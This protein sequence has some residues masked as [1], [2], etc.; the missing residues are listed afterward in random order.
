[1]AR[2]LLAAVVG[3]ALG[4]SPEAAQ[5]E[6]SATFDE[7]EGTGTPGQFP[8]CA[9]A[10]WGGRWETD[11]AQQDP[12]RVSRIDTAAPLGPQG[13]GYLHVRRLLESDG[14]AGQTRSGAS[15]LWS[16][17]GGAV[18]TVDLEFR[19]KVRIDELNGFDDAYSDALAFLEDGRTDAAGRILPYN[20]GSTTSTTWQVEFRIRQGTPVLQLGHSKEAVVLPVPWKAGVVY[21]FQVV[22]RPGT[23]TW[24]V[25]V[26][27][28]QGVLLGERAG[29]PWRAPGLES[30]SGGWCAIAGLM[31]G[32]GQAGSA[33][34][35]SLDDVFIRAAG[36]PGYSGLRRM[37]GAGVA[38]G[39]S[40]QVFPGT[41]T[42]AS[43][44]SM[45]WLGMPRWL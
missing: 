13:G 8:G 36:A 19:W 42:G 41:Q 37:R 39:L 43:T 21:E 28:G 15:R 16:G 32:P 38:W 18:P 30:H 40:G 2:W 27:D 22:S 26:R 45:G 6:F 33:L 7:G 3:W 9:G 5:A 24:D 25:G 29:L 34:A 17:Q 23:K 10:G 35:F 44:K 14:T 1:M 4:A 20:P 11:M 31:R 12:R